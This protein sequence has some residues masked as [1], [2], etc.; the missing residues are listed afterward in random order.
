MT[1]TQRSNWLVVVGSSAGGIDSLS[2]LVSTLPEDFP[3]PIVVAQHLH[4]ERSSHLQNILENRGGLPVHVIED[5]VE[6]ESGNV[7]IAAP[8]TNVE[9]TDHEVS[10][11]P[12]DAMGP[13]PS[14][15]LLFSSAARIYGE[16]V[17]AVIL[18]GT[19][20]DG[21]AGARDVKEAGGTVLIENPQTSA[22]PQMALAIPPTLVDIT[23]EL[24]ALGQLLVNLIT[25]A[26]AINRQENESQLEWLLG[27]LHQRGGI[28]FSTYKSPTILRRI[29]RRMVVTNS[30]NLDEY[31]EYLRIDPEEYEVLAASFLIK[32]TEFF[33]DADVF[34]HLLDGGMQ[35][36]LERAIETG[37]LRVWSA[38]CATGEE[39]YSLAI[40]I[41]ELLGDA[42]DRVNV[43]IFGTDVDAESIAFAR[44]G[45][46]PPASLENVPEELIERYFTRQGDFFEVRKSIRSLVVFGQH[47]LGQ[48]SPFP[49]VDL[50]LCRNVLIYFT[51]ELQRRALQL[52]AFALRDGGLL[53]LGK[54]ETVNPLAEYFSL[55]NPRLKIYRRV[56]SQ[57]LIPAGN[58]SDVIPPS[59]R[60]ASVS[61]R[62]PSP[63]RSRGMGQDPG[64]GQVRSDRLVRYQDVL[65]MLPTGVVI[66]DT[67]Y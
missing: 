18:S 53:I 35:P 52:F 1:T 2:R 55:V 28:D 50:A 10:V 37:E 51:N 8:K 47:D 9:V 49:R 40:V 64:R 4:P 54:A 24:E 29:Q 34:E 44:R 48:R 7:Y 6:I 42:I 56:G 43:R 67:S 59:S 13:K 46:Y 17:I 25:G 15:D 62:M 19:G 22:Y 45:V 57:V 60:L 61:G 20:S 26:Y 63:A 16:R 27:Q 38:G 58:V 33:R 11:R 32:V 23:I 14:I 30:R 66:V 39:A 12:P 41:N 3:A 36:V 65:A 31:I 5:S 21:A